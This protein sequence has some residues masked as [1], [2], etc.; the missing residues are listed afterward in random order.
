MT[1]EIVYAQVT[2]PSGMWVFRA[3]EVKSDFSS[4]LS[5]TDRVNATAW[6]AMKAQLGL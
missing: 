2:W 1:Y 6:D 3:H 5:N 4:R